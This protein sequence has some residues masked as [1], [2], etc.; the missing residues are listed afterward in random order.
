MLS[1]AKFGLARYLEVGVAAGTHFGAGFGA[2]GSLSLRYHLPP[3]PRASLFLR[4]DAAYLR[5]DDERRGQHELTLG[6]EWGF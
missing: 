2:A 5:E 4:Y 6:L 3:V 1:F